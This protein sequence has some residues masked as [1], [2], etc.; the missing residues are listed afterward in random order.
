MA[1]S[2]SVAAVGAIGAAT[3]GGIT[4]GEDYSMDDLLRSAGIGAV[5]AGIGGAATG[6]LG[7][8][9]GGD[10]A[11][12]GFDAAG[13][14]LIGSAG[15]GAGGGANFLGG[16]GGDIGIDAGFAVGEAGIPS[17]IAAE[18][19]TAGTSAGAAAAGAGGGVTPSGG[20]PGVDIVPGGGTATATPAVEE[21]LGLGNQ[22]GGLGGDTGVDAGFAAGEQLPAGVAGDA[23]S[24]LPAESAAAA[25]GGPSAD[26]SAF[27]KPGMELNPSGGFQPI[28]PEPAPQSL[29]QQGKDFLKEYGKP[30]GLAAQVG[31][32]LMRGQGA[33][34]GVGQLNA[35]AGQAQQTAQPLLAGNLTP[36]Q[37]ATFNQTKAAMQAQ[38]RNK[39]ARAGLSGSTM[40]ASALNQVDATV[41]AQMGQ[42]QSV[43]VGQ[44][45]QALGVAGTASG[46]AAALQARRDAET[47]RA[48]QASMGAL[49]RLMAS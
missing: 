28:S 34:P 47:Q 19:S 37:Q 8:G 42:Q 35:I 25:G 11:A 49:G 40:E 14:A 24:A 3:V 43:N 23:V 48:L 31:Q 5:T 30:I 4:G 9:L 22:L 21:G 33:V 12:T 45:L 39:F 36:A 46:N 7:P 18:M 29:W 15:G 44:G 16:L 38:I 2:A 41:L 1:V 32:G 20:I 6:G 10:L 27:D 13:N 17:G 26:V